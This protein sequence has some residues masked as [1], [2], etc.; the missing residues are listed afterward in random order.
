[1]AFTKATK[2]YVGV[3]GLVL[4]QRRIDAVVVWFILV[5]ITRQRASFDII[6]NHKF[7]IISIHDSLLATG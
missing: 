4:L 5:L 3:D 7:Q 6:R 2:G 1:M